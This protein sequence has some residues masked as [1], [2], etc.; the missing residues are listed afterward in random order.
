MNS[1]KPQKQRTC[2]TMLLYYAEEVYA[3]IPKE[4]DRRI[5]MKYAT[6]KNVWKKDQKRYERLRRIIVDK[7]REEKEI[8]NKERVANGMQPCPLPEYDKPFNI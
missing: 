5:L 4:S 7:C 6:R 2:G 3:V 1:I 8:W